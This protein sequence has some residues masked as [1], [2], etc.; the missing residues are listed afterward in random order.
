MVEQVMEALHRTMRD[1][2][3]TN[4]N[5][6]SLRLKNGMPPSEEDEP[7]LQG[8][9]L[10]F[11]ALIDRICDG[12]LG[13]DSEE[14]FDSWLEGYRDSLRDSIETEESNAFLR[15]QVDGYNLFVLYLH[16]LRHP[17]DDNNEG[18]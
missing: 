9:A 18:D 14:A 12:C 1:I 17:S 5:V 3:V 16:N 2:L 6:N 15:G 8:Q 4:W 10:F 13:V 7:F 11:K